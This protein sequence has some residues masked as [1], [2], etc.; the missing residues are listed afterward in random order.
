M[1]NYE[2]YSGKE[3]ADKAV[4]KGILD[5]KEKRDRKPNGFGTREK[6][7]KNHSIRGR[8]SVIGRDCLGRLID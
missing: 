8:N 2:I 5:E 4:I 1:Q 3:F 7:V 6:N